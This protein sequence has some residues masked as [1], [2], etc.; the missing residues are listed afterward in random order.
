VS[1]RCRATPLALALSGAAA[2]G[3][4]PPHAHARRGVLEQD[5]R[6]SPDTAE[7]VGRGGPFLALLRKTKVLR[8]DRRHR[9]LPFVALIAVT[10]IPMVVLAAASHQARQVLSSFSI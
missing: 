1:A 10:W 7:T 2:H 5:D 8:D 3:A 4:R 9:E 6:G